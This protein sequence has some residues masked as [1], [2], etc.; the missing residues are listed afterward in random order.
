MSQTLRPPPSQPLAA[1]A[2]VGTVIAGKYKIVSRIAAGGMGTVYRAEQQALGREVALKLLHPGSMEGLEDS[3]ASKDDFVV[4]EKRFSREAAILAKLQHPNIVTVYDYGSVDERA[5]SDPEAGPSRVGAPRFYMVMELLGGET[6]QHRLT[7]RK[8]LP[9]DEATNIFRQIARGLREAH[10]LG[11]VHR[12]LKPANVMIVRDRDGDEVVKLLDF[13]IGKIL[14]PD[15]KSSST[16]PA[17]A[18]PESAIQAVPNSDDELT[19]DGRFIGSPQYMS[20]EQ[21]TGEAVDE[22]SDIYS[23]GVMF[24]RCLVGTNPF[25]RSSVTMIML[26]HL[27]E[28][29]MSVMEAA[30]PSEVPPWLDTLVMR[31]MQKR[32]DARPQTMEELLRTLQEASLGAR[33]AVAPIDALPAIEPTLPTLSEV[34]RITVPTP[35]TNS[36]LASTEAPAPAPAPSK[37][38]LVALLVAVGVAVLVLTVVVLKKGDPGPVPVSS[39]GPATAEN[40]ASF[41]LTIEST[42]AGAIV[43][44]GDANL[45]T[46]PLQLTIENRGVREKPRTFQLVKDGFQPYA[47]AQGPSNQSVVM[48]AKLMPAPV[49]STAQTAVSPSVPPAPIST[50]PKPAASK[51]TT[52]T[53][54]APTMDIQLKR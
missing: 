20:P 53:A 8:R 40:G 52:P 43:M 28:A 54:T 46:T 51:S 42:P 45:G 30:K 17:P 48:A 6:L 29:P 21:V 16:P 15:A 12:D 25:H 24:Y 41:A 32:K 9:W 33:P 44:E 19:R 11:V 5:S 18:L 10:A 31:C 2:L 39:T 3:T 49:A 14:D 23:F 13:G 34:A 1:D 22:R 26:A 36:A 35:H 47:I 50:G 4:L 38:P 7:S 37:L 27:N